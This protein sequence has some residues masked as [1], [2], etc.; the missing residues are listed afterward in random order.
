MFE[1]RLLID[2]LNGPFF[3]LNGLFKPENLPSL[4]ASG[5]PKIY[6]KMTGLLTMLIWPF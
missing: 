2:G 5:L 6:A 1:E 4:L 3:F